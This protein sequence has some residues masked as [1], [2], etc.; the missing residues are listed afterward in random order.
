MAVLDIVAEVTPGVDA[1][2]AVD[3]PDV[4]PTGVVTKDQ[5]SYI[6]PTPQGGGG[7]VEQSYIFIV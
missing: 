3:R 6:I 7:G 5:T 4:L 2:I 1:V